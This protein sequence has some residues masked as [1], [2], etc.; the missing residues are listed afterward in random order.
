M[1]PI[2]Y[3]NHFIET[4]G[5]RLHVV[6]AGPTDGKPI[7]L[8]HGFPEFWYGWRRQIPALA[9]AGFRLIVPDQR[10]YNLSAVPKD[11]KAYALPELGKDIIGL[12]DYFGIEKVDLVGHDWGAVVAWGVA[13]TFP[14]RVRRLGILNVPHPVVMLRFLSHSPRQ[15]LKSWYVGFFQI[16]GLAD[17]LIKQNNF[18]AGEQSFHATSRPGTFSD[19]EIAHYKQAWSNAGGLT[20]M[21]N[22]YRALVRYRPPNPA[23]IRLHMPVLIQWGKQD[24]FLVHEMAEESV[25]LCNDGK[26]IFYDQ[27][28]HWVQHEAAEQVNLALVD[29]CN[30]VIL[31]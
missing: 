15:M 4:N 20:G 2:P 25:K 13:L 26:L 12:L 18:A 24:A 27:A 11:V 29:F 31:T 10:G 9:Q 7:V 6:T 22:W 16:P 21:I 1:L 5:V 14:G 17:W 8:L 19:E 30:R 23:D 28:T 3:E